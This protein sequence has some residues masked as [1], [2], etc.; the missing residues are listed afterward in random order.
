MAG[1]SAP[2]INSFRKSYGLDW[3]PIEVNAEVPTGFNEL[4]IR[5]E[6]L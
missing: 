3:K 5:N 4:W 6:G 1:I 2:D